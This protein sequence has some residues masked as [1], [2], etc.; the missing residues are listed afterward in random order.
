MH[1]SYS[2]YWLAGRGQNC[3]EDGKVKEMTDRRNICVAEK[4]VQK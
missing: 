2:F 4:R 3:T 1:A